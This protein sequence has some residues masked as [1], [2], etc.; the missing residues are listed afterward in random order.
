MWY[1][2][3]AKNFS[4]PIDLLVLASSK[5]KAQ[6]VAIYGYIDPICA[7]LLSALLLSEPL[8]AG[9]VIGAVSASWISVK[10]SFALYNEAGEA[11]MVLQEKFHRFHYRNALP[12]LFQEWI[13]HDPRMEI[14]ELSHLV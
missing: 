14:L 8:T 12:Q 4:K 2:I 13:T 5:M 3:F 6:E 11:Y 7:I 9:I 1:N 10:T